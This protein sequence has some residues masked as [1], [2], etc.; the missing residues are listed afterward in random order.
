MSD[1]T[2]NNQKEIDQN[3]NA[4]KKKNNEQK[5]VDMLNAMEN[6]F[7]LGEIIFVEIMEHFKIFEQKIEKVDHLE[8]WMS[9][10][11]QDVLT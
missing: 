3:P 6:R 9:D 7:V 8:G 4:K 5:F 10:L 11:N 2:H 1:F